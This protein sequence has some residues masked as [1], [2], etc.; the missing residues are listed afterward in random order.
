MAT[1]PRHHSRGGAAATALFLE[2]FRLD[3]ELMGAVDALISDLGLTGARW[4][5]LGAIALA[6]VSLPVAHIARNMGQSR[7]SVQRVVDDLAAQGLVDFAANPHH[8]RAKLVVLTAAGRTAYEAA[9]AR[10]APWVNRLAADLD[11]PEI[12]AAFRVLRAFRRVLERRPPA[13]TVDPSRP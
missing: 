12:D 13:E 5:V 6:G 9:M 4:Q 7:Q 10:Q 8:R 2:I 1:H 11:P 3:R